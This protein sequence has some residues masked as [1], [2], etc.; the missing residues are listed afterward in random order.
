MLQR[1]AEFDAE[2]AEELDHHRDVFRAL[3][4]DEGFAAFEQQVQ[5]YALGDAFPHSFTPATGSLQA[6]PNRPR[7]IFKAAYL[8]NG[9]AGGTGGGDPLGDDGVRIGNGGADDRM[10]LN[11][12][13]PANYT[14][15]VL[16]GDR[17]ALYVPVKAGST[18]SKD[19]WAVYPILLSQAGTIMRSEFAIYDYQGNL[20]KVEFHV[21]IY[22]VS[23][24]GID[25]MPYQGQESPLVNP[26]AF[27]TYNPTTGYQ[28]NQSAEYS[29]PVVAPIVGWGHKDLPAGYSPKTKLTTV[30]AGT[31]GNV[32]TGLLTDGAPWQYSFFGASDNFPVY[33]IGAD[34][35]NASDVSAACAVYIEYQTRADYQWLYVRG[36]VYRGIES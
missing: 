6:S 32:P 22:P 27:Q 14:G 24:L 12:E 16:V 4:G 2:A 11:P 34:E 30:Q 23:Y 17:E 1:L 26:N 20:A 35:V 25:D 36:R 7:D 31:A 10:L 9:Y 29:M 15:K 19:R 28:I 21:S 5:T 8:P 18:N 3:L 13:G 33:D